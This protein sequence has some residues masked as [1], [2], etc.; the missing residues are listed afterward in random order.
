[1]NRK[2]RYGARIVLNFIRAPFLF[3]ISHGKVRMSGIQLLSP[4]ARIRAYRGGEISLNKRNQMEDGVLLE[5]FKGSIRLNG[6]FINRNTTIVSMNA[7]DIGKNVTIGPN[8]CIYDH[9]HNLLDSENNPFISAP[10]IIE[11]GAWI[12][13]NS[14]ILK[15]VTIGKCAV[16]AAGAVVNRSVPP[17]T[18]TGGVPSKKIGTIDFMKDKR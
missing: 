5:A 2:L 7:I 1:M 3:F 17:Y 10:I 12:G 15:G 6:C 9:D 13:A 14:T 8:V 4:F 16:V 11:N 18:I